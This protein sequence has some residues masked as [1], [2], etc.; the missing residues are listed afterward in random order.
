MQIQFGNLLCKPEGL[1]RGSGTFSHRTKFSGT[2]PHCFILRFEVYFWLSGC[3]SRA[4]TGPFTHCNVRLYLDLTE[5][6]SELDEK[7][8]LTTPSRCKESW[9]TLARVQRGATNSSVDPEIGDR[10]VVI[11]AA[12]PNRLVHCH[13]GQIVICPIKKVQN[14]FIEIDADQIF[15]IS[16]YRVGKFWPQPFNWTAHHWVSCVIR[17]LQMVAVWAELGRCQVI[18]W[19]AL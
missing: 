6:C 14:I 12:W 5:A 2:N 15:A 3:W 16:S 9:A 1:Q 13:V 11:A 10:N 19:R 17:R 18:P 4:P 7:V 8:R